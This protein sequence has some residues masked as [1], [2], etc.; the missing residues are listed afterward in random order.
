MPSMNEI[1]LKY[2]IEYDELVN[3]EDYQSNLKKWLHTNIDFMD[4]LVIEFGTG[5]GRITKQY[6]EKVK[7]AICFDGSIHM[8]DKCR[9]NLKDYNHKIEYQVRDNLNIEGINEK[10]DIIIEGWSFGHTVIDVSADIEKTISKL[11]RNCSQLLKKDGK[12]IIIETLG[13]NTENAAPPLE[14]LKQFY[15]I[16]EKEHMFKKDIITTDYL[17]CNPQEA[18]RIC[19]FFFGSSVSQQIKEKELSHIPE[20]TGIWLK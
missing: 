14:I 16:L 20:Y 11:I 8:L 6:I 5:T 2:S 19:D 10:A 4:K 17:F 3:H 12:I 7:K 15:S 13:T 9:L 1:Y 18:F